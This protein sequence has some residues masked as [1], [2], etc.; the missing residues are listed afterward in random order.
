[1][2][3]WIRFVRHLNWSVLRKTLVSVIEQRLTG[4]SAEMAYYA[5][6]GLFP[7]IIA[8]LMAIGLFETS[9]EL[10]VIQLATR[11]ADIIPQQVW[12]LI[13]EFIR[14]VKLSETT[15]WFSLSSIAAIWFISGVLSAA[16]NALDLIHQVPAA[17]RRS[18]WQTK[19]L[20]IL[21]TICT[22]AFMF[23]ACFLL[24]IG[25]FLFQI[26]LQQSWNQLLL[27]TWKIFSVISILSIFAIAIGS[28]YHFKINLATKNRQLKANIING[29]VIVS[30]L[31][32]Q[33]VYS[34]CV[35][36]QNAIVNSEIEIELT[37]IS[38]YFWRLLGFPIALSLI[39]IAFGLVYRYGASYR[40]PNIPVMPGATIAAVLWA[41]VSLV[42]RIYVS[43]IGMYNEIYGAIGTI[44]V[45]MLWLYLSSLVMLIGEQLN[46]TVGKK[47]LEDCS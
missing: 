41:I 23:V 12:Q 5:M 42:F 28:I 16:I 7:A 29:V 35:V 2:S 21:L 14:E 33:L 4:L 22:L 45:L 10:S 24:G 1:M 32:I 37:V 9:V 25:D 31:L 36:V 3:I 34:G 43:H 27:I 17:Y 20:A 30:A 44:V 39:A 38:I 46:F 26:A 47:M 18:F 19:L 15:S 8:I 11:F 40:Q 13:L 6:L